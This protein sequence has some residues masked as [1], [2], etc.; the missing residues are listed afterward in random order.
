MTMLVLGLGNV[1]MGDDAF[2]PSVIEALNAGFEFPPDVDVMDGGTPGLNLAPVLMDRGALIV[3]D[4]VSAE[5]RP[6]ELRF[7]RKPDLLRHP[8]GPRHGPHEPA[9]GD[10]LAGLELAGCGPAEVYLVGAIPKRVG[11]GVHM[12][13]P[14]RAAVPGAVRAVVDELDRLGLPARPKPQPAQAGAWWES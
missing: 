6:G 1:L 14:L 7:Y 5:G 4:T 3:V 11:G 10:L 13:E 12:S 8:S 9:L 2:G